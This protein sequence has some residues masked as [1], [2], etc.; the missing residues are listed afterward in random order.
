MKFHVTVL[1][2][3]LSSN[4]QYQLALEVASSFELCQC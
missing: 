3:S 4:S 1:S 2:R